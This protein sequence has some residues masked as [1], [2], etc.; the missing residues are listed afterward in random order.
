MKLSIGENIK[1]LRREREITQEEFAAV[2]GVSYQSVS[3]WE[4]GTCYP[5]MELLPEIAEFFGITTDKLIG[6][7]KAAEQKEVDGYLSR[8]QNALS[9]GL[10]YDC[11]K[12][13]RE[14]VKAYP[15]NYTLLN[16][17]M[18]ALF[19]SGDSDGNIPEWKE[20]IKKHDAEIIDLGE[21]ITKYCPDQNIRLEATARLAFQHFEM[22]KYFDEP[23]RR[24][25]SKQLF[26]TLPSSEYCKE[27]A[28]W[29]GCLE[30]HE[31]EA[32]IKD[33]IRNDYQALRSSIWA[34]ATYGTQSD[35]NSI[36]LYNKV[37][38]LEDFITDKNIIRNNWGNARLHFEIAKRYLSLNDFENTKK[39]LKLCLEF[40][41]AFDNRP[42]EQSYFSILLGTVTDKRIDFETADN[43]PLTEIFKNDWLDDEDFDEIK[44]SAGF[45]EFITAL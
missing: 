39:H 29:I 42:D 28:I 31:R 27:N 6:A 34:L 2:F 37:F 44:K 10:V 1:T 22:G 7:D 20:N 21:R 35:E 32:F 15:N 38:E 30:E 13:A 25:I 11:I 4:N 18:Y 45:K 33:K 26:D 19:I 14:G 17:L 43:R 8:F 5:D 12:I 36:I 40:A 41:K 9:K 24:A 23:G 3:R 16:K